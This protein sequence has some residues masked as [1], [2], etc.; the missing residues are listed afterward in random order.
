MVRFMIICLKNN[1]PYI[2]KACPENEINAEW[3]KD[4][5]MDTF[6]ILQANN[7]DVRGNLCDNHTSNVSAYKKLLATFATSV[8][9][10]LAVF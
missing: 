9:D 6:K 3:L 2:I 8:D 1:V 4:Q 7:F 10:R 5:L